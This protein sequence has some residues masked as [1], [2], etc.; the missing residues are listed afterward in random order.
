MIRRRY[1]PPRRRWGSRHQPAPV[2]LVAEDDRGLLL[3]AAA[4]LIWRYRSEL[5]PPSTTAMLALVGAW[6]H[7]R[8]PHW[9]VPLAALTAAFSAALAVP[10]H[11][12]AVGRWATRWTVL[13]RPAERL[14]AASVVGLGGAWLTAAAAFGPTRPPLPT[15]AMLGTLAAGIPWWTHHRRR[16]RVRVERTI[17]AWPQ[18]ADAIGLPGSRLVSAVVDRWGWTGRLALRRGQTA[19]HAA[20]QVGAIESALGVRPGGVRVEPDPRRADRGILRVVETDPHAEPIPWRAPVAASASTPVEIGV[21]E[22]GSPVRVRLAYRNTLVGGVVGSGKSGVLNVLL[23]A[24]VAC[25]DVAAWGIDRKGGMELRP[26]LSCL[27]RLATDATDA[28]ELL[29]AAVAVLDARAELLAARGERL[30]RPTATAPALVILVD[31]YAELPDEAAGYADSI[32]RRGRAV[33]VTLLVATQR[34][35]QQA[36]GHGAVRSQMDTRICLRVRERRDADLI[37]GQGMVA[38]GWRADAL[39]APGKFLIS[40]PEHTSPRP[41]RAYLISD[42]DVRVT[43]TE[44]APRRPVAGEVTQATAP[45]L[46]HSRAGATSEPERGRPAALLWKALQEAPDEGVSVADLMRLAGMSRPWTYK[47]LHEHAVAGRAVQ[48]GRGRWRGTAPLG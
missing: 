9:A 5:A 22:D 4:R 11:W 48:T 8:H 12:W 34:P 31:E 42:A 23:A 25:A 32:A 39:D 15:V 27:G 21:F 46:D 40:D 18:F 33:A 30:W 19:R 47:R 24:L 7:A 14:Y 36:M 41:A 28:T 13:S 45:D 43:V 6:A 2:L 3:A 10:P 1:R 44:H 20:D 29:R 38:A 37:L 35:T 26:W 16:A 17:A